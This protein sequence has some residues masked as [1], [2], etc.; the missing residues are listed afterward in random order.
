[1]DGGDHFRSTFSQRHYD[2]QR[3]RNRKAQHEGSGRKEGSARASG[4]AA[5]VR[6]PFSNILLRGDD[7][8]DIPLIIAHGC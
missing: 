8:Y 1:M 5:R 6:L 4:V 7:I 3:K 2:R